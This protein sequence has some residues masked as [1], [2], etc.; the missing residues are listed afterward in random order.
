VRWARVLV[1]GEV[2]GA[3]T[4][5][6]AIL[7]GVGVEDDEATASALADQIIELRAFDDGSGRMNLAARDVAAAFL[8]ISQITLHADTS[9]GRRPSFAKAAPRDLA[10]H[11][12]DSFCRVVRDQGF[13]V[14]TGRFGAMM[15]V[16]LCN[17]GPVTIVLSTDGW[18]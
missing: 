12:V 4:G 2:V 6:W 11:L 18:T 1:D 7:L 5:G 8:V 17:D 10:I 13:S 16:E 15:D 3:I 14:A 9:K